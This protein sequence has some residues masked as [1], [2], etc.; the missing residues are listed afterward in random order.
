M[1]YICYR[2]LELS[3]RIQ[4]C[5]LGIE[6]LVLVIFA[7]YALVQVFGSTPPPNSHHPHLGLAVA[8]GP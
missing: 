6:L 2:G 5:L 1:T 3:A 8:L 7:V 4:Y